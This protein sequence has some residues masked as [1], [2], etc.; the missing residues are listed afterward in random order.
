MLLIKKLV[1][2]TYYYL[3]DSIKPVVDKWAPVIIGDKWYWK[4]RANWWWNKLFIYDLF[5]DPLGWIPYINLRLIR[6]YE[7]YCRHKSYYIRVYRVVFYLVI[8]YI[9]FYN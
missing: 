9:L 4:I 3:H 1:I 8:I 2:K 5:T 6:D 7:Y